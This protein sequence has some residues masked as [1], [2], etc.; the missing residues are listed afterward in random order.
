MAKPITFRRT[1]GA[2]SFR[3]GSGHVPSWDTDW[4]RV[5]ATESFGKVAAREK[6]IPVAAAT[7]SPKPSTG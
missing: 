5:G 6:T 2:S 7:A 1:R 3:V 4:I